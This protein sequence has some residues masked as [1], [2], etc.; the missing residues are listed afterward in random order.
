[1][2]PPC[3]QGAGARPCGPVTAAGWRA[4]AAA[5]L[6]AACGE[7]PASDGAAGVGGEAAAAATAA[8]TAWGAAVVRFSPGVGAGFGQDA[9]PDVVLGPP[10]GR[11]PGAG[12]LDVVSLGVAGEIVLSFDG[13]RWVVDGPGADLLV[14]EN[15]FWAG[16]DRTKPWAEPGAVAVS[17]DG[18][19]WREFPC[20]AEGDGQGRWPGCAGWTP[21]L[22]FEPPPEG[23]GLDP[24]VTGGDAFDLAEI[25]VERAAFVRIRDLSAGPGGGPPGAGFDLDAVAAVYSIPPP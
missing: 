10:D 7:A 14:F 25:G 2:D 16:G 3:A 19:L 23:G 15:A 17:E 4:L 18:A 5:W 8:V 21:T 20:L 6:P 9:L 13:G 1:M 11:A 22:D 24:E 12:S